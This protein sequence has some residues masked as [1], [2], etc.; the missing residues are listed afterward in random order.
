MSTWDYLSSA[1]VDI[2]AAYAAVVDA[3]TVVDMA[4]RVHQSETAAVAAVA[5]VAAAD[6]VVVVVVA[7][8]AAA[9]VVAAA[10]GEA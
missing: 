6:V 1:E 10:A 3:D 2:A 8:A 5:V 9:A 4:C 7:A